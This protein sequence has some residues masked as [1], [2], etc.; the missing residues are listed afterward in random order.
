M[1]A[2]DAIYTRRAIR[3]FTD[4]RP[5]RKIVEQLLDA[6]AQAPSAMNLQPWEFVVI[7]D[8]DALDYISSHCREFILDITPPDSPQQVARGMLMDDAFDIFYDATTL[9]AICATGPGTIEAEDCFLAA[10]N[11]MLAAHAIGLAT[12]PI[13]FARPWLNTEEAKRYLR[14]PT[15]CS[16][17]FPL[18]LGYPKDIP[19]PR[20]RRAPRITLWRETKPANTLA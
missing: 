5:S 11:L 15:R 1:E 4:E 2:L 13:G 16:P 7:Q 10:Q 12:C 17:A 18:I 3:S 8:T 6:A 20:G 9:I 19:P 14:I